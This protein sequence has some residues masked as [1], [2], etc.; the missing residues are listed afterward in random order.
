M[1][2]RRNENIVNILSAA[3]FAVFIFGIAI[4]NL[5]HGNGSFSENENRYLASFPEVS[6]QNVF[7][8]DFDTEF[9]TWF[10]DQFIGRDTWIERKAAARRS[11]GAIENNGVYFASGQR[12]IQQF[13]SYDESQ[14]EHNIRYLL[15][16]AEENKVRLNVL[17]VPG[18]GT[19][20]KKFLPFGAYNVDE[21]KL[22][23]DIYAQ[24]PSQNCIE[25]A[26]ALSSSGDYYFHTDH[27]WNAEGAKTGYDA[28]CRSVLKKES[29]AFSY[30]EVSDDF[31]GTMYSRSGAFWTK[32][33]P[34]IRI[35]PVHP[36]SF[37]V[38][39][40]DGSVMHSL[41]ADA[42]LKEKDKYTY[43]LDGNHP[44]VNIKTDIEGGRR[45]V[46]IKDSFAHILLPFLACEYSEIDMFDL[47]YYNGS[48]SEYI[49]DRE[50]TDVYVIYGAETFCTD[51]N[52]AVLW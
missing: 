51:K 45:A 35:D 33:D 26:P 6:A 50:N 46:I 8:G 12:L 9:E 31:K 28:I 25:I 52:L 4:V 44:Y 17:L 37:T 41:Y 16:F 18:A 29:L 40:E 15:D 32:A 22:I 47:R 38:T 42:R 11:M 7:F 39:F 10:S 48:V 23:S 49:K 21:T 34:V 30:T 20:E 27:H 1:K 36:R 3:V 13:L 5:F 19:G 14:L 24:M 2:K 43:Y